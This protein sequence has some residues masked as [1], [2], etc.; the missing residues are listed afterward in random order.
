MNP[1]Q[2]EQIGDLAKALATAQGELEFA[3]KDSQNPHFRNTYASLAS[4][5][6]AVRPVFS[7]H[8]LSVSQDP[9]SGDDGSVGVATTLMHASGQWKRSVLACKP[10]KAGPQDIGS[11]ITYF[12][13]YAM[14]AVAGIA[15][16]DDDAETSHGRSRTEAREAPQPKQQAASN[17]AKQMLAE[18][19]A[20][21]YDTAAK[22]GTLYQEV[23]S[24]ARPESDEER[25]KVIDHL[26]SGGGE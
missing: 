3:I 6:E 11:V 26:L 5:I 13:R 4:V 18:L 15:Q 2:S 25:Q 22:V 8:G 1:T 12:R 9:V 23:L 19:K 21:G 16:D 17:V 7:K 14:A 24:K 20:A 10:P